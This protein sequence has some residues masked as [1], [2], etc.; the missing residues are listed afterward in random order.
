MTA[1]GGDGG[2]GVDAADQLVVEAAGEETNISLKS[3]II[4]WTT[5]QNC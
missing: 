2:G 5:D 4:I 1:G 3:H